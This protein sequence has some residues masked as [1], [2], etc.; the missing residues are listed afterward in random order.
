[1][2]LTSLALSTLVFAKPTAN[3][4]ADQLK[5]VANKLLTRKVLFVNY[6]PGKFDW[7]A[8]LHNGKFVAKLNGLNPD[9]T[10][11]YTILGDPEKYGL[12]VN[13]TP[14]GVTIENMAQ[15]SVQFDAKERTVADTAIRAITQNS[16]SLATNVTGTFTGTRQLDSAPISYALQ[17]FG[18]TANSYLRATQTQA[19]PDGGSIS[20]N[21]SSQT[22]GSVSFNSCIVQGSTINGRVIVYNATQTSADVGLQHLSVENSRYKVYLDGREKISMQSRTSFSADVTI[23]TGY[24][25]DKLNNYKEEYKNYHYFVDIQGNRITLRVNGE[26]KN[27]CL[28]EWLR[29][30]TIT[31][32][33]VD[34]YKT[35]PTAGI[36]RA[37]SS[38]VDIKARFNSD[39]SIDVIDNKTGTQT[40]HYESCLEVGRDPIC[41][42]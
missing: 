6:G 7:I 1:M 3:E 34:K 4:V 12:R 2:I 10:F 15:Q 17:T 39:G 18:K 25:L 31:P 11:N 33:S 30:S 21:V 9:G 23:P 20:I 26:L 19:C 40:K 32:I 27:N 8:V 28:T 5:Q 41:Q 36:V 22:S 16:I 35:C 14:D 42:N 24:A 38:S 37:T 29:I 13:V